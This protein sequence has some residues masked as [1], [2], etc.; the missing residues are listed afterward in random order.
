VCVK[1]RSLPALLGPVC[2]RLPITNED[3]RA[4]VLEGQDEP[5]LELLSALLPIGLLWEKEGSGPD[6]LTNAASYLAG[7][8][9]EGLPAFERAIQDYAVAR[10]LGCDS[11]AEAA[12][13]KVEAD[14]VGGFWIRQLDGKLSGQGSLMKRIGDM[15]RSPKLSAWSEK[16]KDLRELLLAPTE[17]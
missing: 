7:V 3:I 4:T 5:V 6:G 11:G 14:S 17:E 15:A 8:L 1:Q 16:L 2:A 12:W 13:G 10:I 9:R